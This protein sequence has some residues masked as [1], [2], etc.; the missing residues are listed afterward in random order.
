MKEL[1]GKKIGMTRVFGAD[2]ESV[3]VS[4]IEVGPCVVID[5]KTKEKHGYDAI[6][7]G[8]GNSRKKLFNKPQLGY[9]EK[10]N[11]EPK[12]Y[13]REVTFDEEVN[14]GDELKVDI[15]KK[16]QVVD[17]TGISRGLGFQG[18]MKRH[19]FSGAQVTHGQSDRERAPGSIGQSSYPSRVW[20][21]MKMAGKTGKDRVTVLNLRIVDIIEDQNLLLVKG[22]VPGK[23]GTLLKVRTS[24]RAR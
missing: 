5:K 3:P 13:L 6:Q 10:N 1:I 20:K 16:G 7:I 24:N 9:F 4:V 15:F 19:G 17:V 12:K 23:K 8:Y 2:G 22:A 18:A 14:V 11:I 21:G